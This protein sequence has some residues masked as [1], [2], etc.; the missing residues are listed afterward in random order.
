[1][2]ADASYDLVVGGGPAGE[3]AAAAFWGKRVAVVDRSSELGG[4]MIGGAVASK[5][6]REAALYLTGFKRRDIYEVNI[7][8]TPEVAAERVRRRTDDVATGR[9]GNTE[10]LGLEEAGVTTDARGR[11]VVDHRYRAR[12]PRASSHPLWRD[13]RALSSTRP[14]NVPTMSEAYKYAAYDGPGQVNR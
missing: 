2:A 5:T 3:K 9:V 1:M 10:H 6:M 11:I 7:A 12:A 4:A 14:S 8:L 13:H